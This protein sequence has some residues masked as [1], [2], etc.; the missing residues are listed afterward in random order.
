VNLPE[1]AARLGAGEF[2]VKTWSENE[3]LIAPALV[4]GCFVDTGR[5]V[6]LGFVAAVVRRLAEPQESF[7]IAATPDPPTAALVRL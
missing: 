6:D 1:H 3:G 5:R 4:S 2:F 7:A